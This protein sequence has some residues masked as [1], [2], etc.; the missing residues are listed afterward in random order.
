MQTAVDHPSRKRAVNLS[1]SPELI[2]EVRALSGN[3]SATVETMLTEYVTRERG[4][5][6]QK[7]RDA[8][9]VC[10][11]WNAVLDAQGGSFADPYSPL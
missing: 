7:R 1:L 11:Q 6:E 5:R 9:A 3:L 4:A 8:T 10:R 2:D